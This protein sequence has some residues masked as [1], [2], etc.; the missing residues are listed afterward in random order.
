MTSLSDQEVSYMMF[1]N[2]LLIEFQN[3]SKIVMRNDNEEK[4]DK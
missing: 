2:L 3:E 1:P 4:M